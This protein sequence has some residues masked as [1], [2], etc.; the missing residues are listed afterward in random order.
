MPFVSPFIRTP[1]CLRF[2]DCDGRQEERRYER[3]GRGQGRVKKVGVGYKARAN[4]EFGPV[5]IDRL[6]AVDRVPP[7]AV[8]FPPAGYK[9]AQRAFDDE[10]PDPIPEEEDRENGLCVTV[11]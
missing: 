8:A 9:E 4:A 10:R 2:T 1:S 3:H 5:V 11:P 6:S 7:Q